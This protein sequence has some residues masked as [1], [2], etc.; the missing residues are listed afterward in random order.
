MFMNLG[1]CIQS[2][3]ISPLALHIFKGVSQVISL[4]TAFLLVFY[5]YYILPTCNTFLAALVE[6]REVM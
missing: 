1:I 6:S 4:I 5:I 3:I 2:S